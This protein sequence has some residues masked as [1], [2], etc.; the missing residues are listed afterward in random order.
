MKGIGISHKEVKVLVRGVFII[1]YGGGSKL[2]DK[3]KI[4][5]LMP[6]YANSCQLVPIHANQDLQSPTQCIKKERK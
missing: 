1:T 5:L 6:T 4:W 2:A 3:T